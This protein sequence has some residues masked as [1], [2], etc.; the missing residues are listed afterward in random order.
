MAED[1]VLSKELLLLLKIALKLV[2]FLMIT[3]IETESHCRIHLGIVNLLC[4][5]F[6]VSKMVLFDAGEVV[7]DSRHRCVRI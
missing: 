5:F 2:E 6:M 4:C 7:G 3:D 1:P